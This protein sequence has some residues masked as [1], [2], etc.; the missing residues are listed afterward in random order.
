MK[1]YA[2]KIRCYSIDLGGG[3]CTYYCSMFSAVRSQK[4]S[5]I[6]TSM[7]VANYRVGIVLYL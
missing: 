3:T 1:I 6:G 5:A 2:I 4:S 7:F